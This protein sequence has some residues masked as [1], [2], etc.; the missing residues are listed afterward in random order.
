[1]LR[2]LLNRTVIGGILLLIVCYVAV[3][4]WIVPKFRRPGQMSVVEALAMDMRAMRPPEGVVP[5]TTEIVKPMPFSQ[6]VTYTG[7]VVPTNEEWVIARVTGRLT[8]LPYYAGD[9]VRKGQ[10]IARLDHS[11]GEYAAREEQARFSAQAARHE[12]HMA[13]AE[14]DEAAAAVARAESELWQAKSARLQAEKMVAEKEAMVSEAEAK[15]R[16]AEA[17]LAEA[18]ALVSAKEKEVAATRELIRQTEAEKEEAEQE[19]VVKEQEAAAAQ[20]ELEYWSAAIDRAKR[21]YEAKAIS[22]DEF[23]REQSQYQVAQAQAAKARAEVE[24]AKRKVAA[25]QAALRQNQALLEQKEAERES[26]VQRW[27]TVQAERDGAEARLQQARAALDQAH[28]QLAQAQAEEKKGEASVREAKARQNRAIRHIL[29]SQAV[30]ASARA[31]LTLARIVRSYTEIRA[32]TDGVVIERLVSPGNLVSAGT[33][34]LRIGQLDFVRVQAFVSERDLKSIRIGTPAVVRSPTGDFQQKGSVTALFPSADPTTRTGLVEVRL[35]NP[36]LRWLPGQS[37][38][39]AIVQDQHQNAISVPNEALTQFN[40]QPAVWLA[41]GQD[42]QGPVEYTC[43]MH[44][45]VLQ[46]KPGRC[47]LCGMDLVP[48]QRRRIS[49]H[50]ATKSQYTCPMHP[51]VMTDKP[52][53]CPKCG[54]DLVPTQRAT[55]NTKIARIRTVTLGPTDGVR[56]IVLDSLRTGDE[57]IVKG[58]M[59]LKE[60]D[61][62]QVVEWTKEGTPIVP[63]IPPSGPSPQP[64][65]HL[66]QH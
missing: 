62:V 32:L 30:E 34:I 22:K 29:H 28:A 36:R 18:R 64:P 57:V 59:N 4:Y 20:S 14:R 15:V 63:L 2:S 21:L 40:G 3:F 5:V 11:A 51:E 8:W 65:S 39:V 13:E 46:D 50:K 35:P 49:G 12:R 52:G 45:D 26:A 25:L 9:R 58:W 19:I 44:P 42:D 33:P 7:T 37:V 17:S 1:M 23:Q 16:A 10:L 43:P 61:F 41:V 38:I 24:K 53:R 6:T 27:Q 66:H 56:T 60:G 48:K 54:M 47:P 55:V 31:G